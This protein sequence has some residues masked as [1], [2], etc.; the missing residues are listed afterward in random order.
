MKG[1]SRKEVVGRIAVQQGYSS[2]HCALVNGFRI[3]LMCLWE[4]ENSYS[5]S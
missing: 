4:Q 1:D 3:M 2:S 5:V